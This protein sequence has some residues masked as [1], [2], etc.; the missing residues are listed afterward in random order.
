[1]SHI[2]YFRVIA[3]NKELREKYYTFFREFD[4]ERAMIKAIRYMADM[5]YECGH[6][7]EPD[8]D[9]AARFGWTFYV[10][11]IS[12]EDYYNAMHGGEE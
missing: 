6:I 11:E 12:L 3:E 5:A 4:L 8:G 7:N 2:S 9:A 1:M 10:E